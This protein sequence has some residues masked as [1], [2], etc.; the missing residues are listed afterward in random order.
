MRH[1]NAEWHGADIPDFD[2]PLNRKGSSEAEAMGRHLRLLELK[3]TLLLTSSARRAQQTSEIV[4][5]E[6]GLAG[7]RIRSEGSLYL[8]AAQ[9]LL[10]VVNATGPRIPHLMIIGHNPGISEV[11]NLL[12]PSEDLGG[13][14]TGALHTL[15]FDARTWAEVCAATIQHSGT[16]TARPPCDVSL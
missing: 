14:G 6:L 1:A 13:L 15:A 2:R 7:G 4:A 3:P 10:S 9:T 8:A 12:A 11:S 5:R 16:F